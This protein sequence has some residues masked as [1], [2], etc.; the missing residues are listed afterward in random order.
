MRF[1]LMTSC[2]L[3]R[4]SATELWRHLILTA[5]R[6]SLV[7]ATQKTAL[8]TKL[9]VAGCWGN[10]CKKYKLFLASGSSV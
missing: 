5:E 6:G 4:R 8:S 7:S 10:Y 3:D 2:L 9:H 1:E